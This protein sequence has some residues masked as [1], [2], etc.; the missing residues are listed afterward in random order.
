[1]IALTKTGIPTIDLLLDFFLERYLFEQRKRQGQPRPWSDWPELCEY[2]FCNSFR[3]HDKGSIWLQDNWI[4]PNATDPDLTFAVIVYRLGC[5]HPDTAEL[6][7]YPI[8]WQSERYLEAM[9]RRGEKALSQYYTGYRLPIPTQ[10]G[11][12]RLPG[13]AQLLS[14][15]WARRQE[16]RAVLT[17]GWTLLRA[18]ELL[19]TFP[20]MGEFRS[21]QVLADLKQVPP[22]S[23]APDFWTFCAIGPGSQRGLNRLRGY[24]VEKKWDSMIWRQHVEQLG[25]IVR[26]VLR[27]TNGALPLPDNQNIN[28]LLCETDKLLRIRSGEKHNCRRYIPSVAVEAPQSDAARSIRTASRNGRRKENPQGPLSQH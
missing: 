13:L 26:K 9:Q 8:P 1:M 24:P 20:A 16:L 11:T 23:Q 3:E 10:K 15:Y 22:L 4:L 25:V 21:A 7:G 6:I 27:E 17:P 28:N 18:H 5:N 2:R 12:L 19:C 14:D